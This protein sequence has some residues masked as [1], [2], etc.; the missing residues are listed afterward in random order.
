MTFWLWVIC[1][2]FAQSLL[3]MYV[4]R[5]NSINISQA[6]MNMNNLY[7]LW[8]GGC[9]WIAF[10]SVW[11]WLFIL[12]QTLYLMTGT[13]LL[14]PWL[15]NRYNVRERYCICVKRSLKPL[16]F[17]KLFILLHVF[18]NIQNKKRYS[19]FLNSINKMHA[20][21]YLSSCFIIL[22]WRLYTGNLSD[23]KYCT[24]ITNTPWRECLWNLYLIKV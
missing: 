16:L 10:V 20:I 1:E 23:M 12:L 5:W 22:V 4:P 19:R 9:H 2:A 15:W 6:W 14:F 13:V 3:R 18:Q 8:C 21:W 24:C 11:I 17:Y 7:C